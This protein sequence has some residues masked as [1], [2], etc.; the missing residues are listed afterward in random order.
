[1]ENQKM[2]YPLNKDFIMVVDY[3]G[4]KWYKVRSVPGWYRTK[5]EVVIMMKYL[6]DGKEEKKHWGG[7]SR[8]VSQYNKNGILIQDFES[9]SQAYRYTGVHVA[10]INR[11]C[12][13]LQTMG[14]DFM[15][16]YTEEEE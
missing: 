10:S 2:K 1:M 4:I 6:N 16:K 13:N 8:P 12:K 9:M 15:W 5:K 14:G 7:R 3:N 11:C